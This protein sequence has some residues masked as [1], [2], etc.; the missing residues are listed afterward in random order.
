MVSIVYT[1]V[2]TEEQAREG[3]S[4]A[5]QLEACRTKATALGATEIVECVDEGASGEI[6]TRPQLTRAREIMRQGGIN[7]FV[8]LDPDRLARKLAHQLLITEEIERCGVRLEYVNF[9]R[10]N[11]PEG[12]L[13]YAIRG[14]IAEYEKEKIK[15]RTVRAKGQ[16]RRPHPLAR[17]VRLRLHEEGW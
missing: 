9:D 8:C 14:A 4:L 5:S 15:E 3:Y 11:N 13:L 12:N 6:L 16:A 2:S 1:R 7:A 17:H 10:A